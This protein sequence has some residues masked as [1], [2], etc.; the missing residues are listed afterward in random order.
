MR[1]GVEFPKPSFWP[2][3]P[4]NSDGV[5][6]I[7]EEEL[8]L[9]AWKCQVEGLEMRSKLWKIQIFSGQIHSDQ[10]ADWS[11]QNGGLVRGIPPKCPK[12][13]GLGIIL[14]ILETL[15]NL[16]VL[17][18]TSTNVD[19]GSLNTLTVGGTLSIFSCTNGTCFTFY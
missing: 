5:P 11:P 4:P 19:L 17:S 3:F 6:S 12:H 8:P 10:P 15:F 14:V 1:W 16:Q 18:V 13:S 7:G 9:K 2:I